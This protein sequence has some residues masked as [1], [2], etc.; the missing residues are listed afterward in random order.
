MDDFLWE[1]TNACWGVNPDSRP[2]ISDIIKDLASFLKNKQH[3][4]INVGGWD[5][6]IM[7]SLHSPWFESGVT[8]SPSWG[9]KR[10][11]A[12]PWYFLSANKKNDVTMLQIVKALSRGYPR[13]NL[14]SPQISRP[15]SILSQPFL[16]ANA[17][18]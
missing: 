3:P 1:L 15:A 5:E 2:S 18:L 14:Q 9:M 8:L 12:N 13:R 17:R 11:G 10:R 6:D 7:S 4:E 16:K